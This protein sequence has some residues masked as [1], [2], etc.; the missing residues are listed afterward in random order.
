M[1]SER[2]ITRQDSNA[3]RGGDFLQVYGDTMNKKKRACMIIQ[4]CLI[5]LILLLLFNYWGPPRFV[6]LDSDSFCY[7][8][9]EQTRTPFC[10]SFF[11][12]S[13]DTL[14]TVLPK[15][16]PAQRYLD[17]SV[18]PQVDVDTVEMGDS[19]SIPLNYSITIALFGDVEGA[20]RVFGLE[21]AD[22]VY[23][24][25]STHYRSVGCSDLK[26]SNFSLARLRLTSPGYIYINITFNN[27]GQIPILLSSLDFSARTTDLSYSFLDM[28]VNIVLFVASLISAVLF[29]FNIKKIRLAQPA[30]ILFEQKYLWWLNLAMV[31]WF[32][33]ISI[34]DTYFP[35]QFTMVWSGIWN[36]V[37]VSCFLLFW[38]TM[39]RR[40][41]TEDYERGTNKLHVIFMVAAAIYFILILVVAMLNVASTVRDPG[42]SARQEYPRATTVLFLLSNIVIVVM[43]CH[44]IFSS[45]MMCLKWRG[46]PVRHKAFFVSSFSFLIIFAVITVMRLAST[47]GFDFL[48]FEL[49]LFFFLAVMNYNE[50]YSFTNKSTA[51]PSQPSAPRAAATQEAEMLYSGSPFTPAPRGVFDQVLP[52]RV[53]AGGFDQKPPET[54]APRQQDDTFD[55]E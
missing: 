41:I 52:P 7:M 16:L 54:G 47:S 33:P 6:Y 53:P 51:T 12:K 17:L 46:R 36:A 15:L 25:N 31:M 43:F 19:F 11:L 5:Q 32:N 48:R 10:K 3:P 14:I 23:N 28:L 1:E 40:I 20:Q 38:M 4:N 50:I 35:S 37:F 18:Q 22:E 34:A 13:R 30:S 27:T 26:C 24:R 42:F 45:V 55:W 2:G 49:I 21:Y 39:Y 29:H 8:D 44:F 9:K